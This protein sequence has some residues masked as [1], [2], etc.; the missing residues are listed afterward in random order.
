MQAIN[1][2][3]RFWSKVDRT[4][5]PDAC[6]P[7]RAATTA[8]GYP[9]YVNPIDRL[10]RRYLWF[11]LHGERPKG[12][13]VS[14]RLENVACVN[15]SHLI[16][17]THAERAQT[18]MALGRFRSP[19]IGATPRARSGYAGLA[20]AVVDARRSRYR[21]TPE[22]RRRGHASRGCTLGSQ[23]RR[24]SFDIPKAERNILLSDPCVYCHGPS[25]EVD[26]IRPF[27]RGG[28]HDWMN[29]A[30]T[31]LRCNRAKNDKG[32]LRFL[33]ARRHAA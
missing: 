32:L 31:C 10:V 19:F 2:P 5:G 7:W 4:G 9:I 17:R 20:K 6:W 29:R 18:V 16:R 24:S 22:D 23:R 33:I 21:I 28:S 3:A 8:Q 11:L 25:N 12:A 27:A 30:P 26:H 15:P 13:L 1:L 14:C